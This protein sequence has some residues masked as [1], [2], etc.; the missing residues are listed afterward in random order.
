MNNSI[1]LVSIIIPTFRRDFAFLQKAIDSLINQTYKNIEII[2]IDDNPPDSVYRKST[3]KLLNQYSDNKKVKYYTNKKNI[4]GS[5]ARNKG[6]E[7]ASGKYITFLDDDD[8]YLPKKVESQL[9]FMIENDYDMSFTNLKLI[10]NKNIVIDYREYPRLNCN[11][12]ND[13]FKYHLMRHLTGTPTFMYKTLKIREIGGFDDVN[14]GQEF[15][16]MVK[17]IKYNLKI[18]YLQNCNVIALRHNSGGI[19]QGINKIIG[20]K[21]LFNFKKKYFYLFSYR[22]KMFIRFRH[23]AVMMIAYKRN[24]NYLK[25]FLSFGFMITSSPIDFVIELYRFVKNLNKIR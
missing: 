5:R 21:K 25:T 8:F 23:H 14:F 2:V 15:F 13:L 11:N 12:N 24:R 18:G 6:I 19:S 20:E 7:L 9:N 16:L 4:G 3:T 1:E 17:T 22:E 10:N